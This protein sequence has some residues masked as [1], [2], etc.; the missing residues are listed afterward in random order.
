MRASASTQK[1]TITQHIGQ[2]VMTTSGEVTGT[3]EDEGHT[4]EGDNR[5]MNNIL[6]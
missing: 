3:K 6:T 4:D 2:L 1:D 5:E